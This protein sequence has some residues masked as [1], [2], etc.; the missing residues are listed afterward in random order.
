MMIKE[1]TDL[2]RLFSLLLILLLFIE[3]VRFLPYGHADAATEKIS[4]TKKTIYTGETFKLK[5]KNS[6]GT[7][8]WTS[9]DKSIATVSRKKGRVKGI[10]EGTTVI[11]AKSGNKKYSCSVTVRSKTYGLLIPHEK[12]PYQASYTI[13][14]K[15]P[16]SLI[17]DLR[18]ALENG[19]SYIEVKYD[20]YDAPYWWKIIS[21]RLIYY[22]ELSGYMPAMGL[23]AAKEDSSLILKPTYKKAWKAITYLRHTD[24]EISEEVREV[25]DAAYQMANEAISLYPDDIKEAL[26]Y[27]NNRICDMTTY[28]SPI[29]AKA[30][31]PQRDADGVFFLGD[32]VCEA[33]TAALRIIL[34]I[35]GIENNVLVNNR[36]SHIWNYVN[37]D[38]TWY[39]IDVTWNDIKDEDGNYTNVYFL[40]TDEEIIAIDE[41]TNERYRYRWYE[42][43]FM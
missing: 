32:G 39:H 3:C 41:A 19:A 5:I 37:I 8:K 18:E 29:P 34:N 27:I 28:S 14:A 7:F 22:S 24:Y 35:L 2:K 30:E 38:G 21:N 43:L 13:T 40:L 26:L 16:D 6:S 15:D 9:A 4:R 12:T 31:C 20:R 33:Y 17:L 36:G 25:L 11:T 1:K 10:S 42:P 23:Y